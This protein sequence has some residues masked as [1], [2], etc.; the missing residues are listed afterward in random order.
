MAKR[1]QWQIQLRACRKA[2]GQSLSE[3]AAELGI[4]K[5]HL[6]DLEKGSAG[7]P[8]LQLV[9]SIKGRYGFCVCCDFEK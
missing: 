4:T 2:N 3:A 7:N 9:K 1:T 6:F 8:S 5:G